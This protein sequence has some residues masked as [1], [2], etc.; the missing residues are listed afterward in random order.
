MTLD[1]KENEVLKLLNLPLQED[2]PV[3]QKEED[4]LISYIIQTLKDYKKKKT[5][6]KYPKIPLSLFANRK[7]GVLEITV[8]FL[9]E[10]HSLTYSQ[11]ASILN[12]DY[13]TIWVTYKRACSKA[14]KKFS[15]PNDSILIP[16][17]LFSNRGVGPFE[18][19][20][21]HLKD[22]IG[23]KL[24]DIAYRLNRGY[25]TVWITY[26]NAKKDS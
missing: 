9:K 7:L 26:R 11:I 19:L 24:K 4:E 22:D 8:K 21:M 5:E 1:R 16:S 23:L 18:V 14:K 3:E 15:M 10:N 2:M 6:D 20:V 25:S 13:R 17:N 12:R